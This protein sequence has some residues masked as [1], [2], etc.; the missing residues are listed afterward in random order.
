MVDIGGDGEIALVTQ[1]GLL[2]PSKAWYPELSLENKTQE[3]WRY[4][5][6]WSHD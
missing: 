3:R 4:V 1:E 2:S 5:G 6:N